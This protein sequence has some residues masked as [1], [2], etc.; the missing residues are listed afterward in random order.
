MQPFFEIVGYFIHWFQNE[1]F[2]LAERQA[3]TRDSVRHLYD[4]AQEGNLAVLT[5]PIEYTLPWLQTANRT[6]NPV[7]E[8]RRDAQDA[9]PAFS[10]FIA[11]ALEGTVLFEGLPLVRRIISRTSR[12]A[13]APVELITD[14]IVIRHNAP[15]SLVIRARVITMPSIPHPLIAIDIHKRLWAQNLRERPFGRGRLSGYAL[16]AGLPI[17]ITFRISP[18]RR[19]YRLGRDYLPIAR[20]FELPTDADGYAIVEGVVSMDAC[21]VLVNHRNGFGRHTVDVGVPEK[22]KIEAFERVCHHLTQRGFEPWKGVS[23]IKT[24]NSARPD[25]GL[26]PAKTLRKLAVDSSPITVT[27]KEQQELERAAQAIE[28]NVQM[29]NDWHAADPMIVIAHHAGCHNDAAFAKRIIYILTNGRSQIE[30]VTV[31]EEAHGPRGNLPHANIDNAAER[32]KL[33]SEAWKKWTE[34]LRESTQA[35]HVVGCLVMAPIWYGNQ[36]DDPVNKP[37]ARKS[38]AMWSGLLVQYLLPMDGEGETA[39]EA[40]CLRIQAAWRDL[41]WAHYGRFKSVLEDVS[42]LFPEGTMPQEIVGIAIV[43]RNKPRFGQQGSAVPVAI[44]LDVATRE[45]SMRFAYRE[46]GGIKITVWEG[47]RQGLVRLAEYSP[48]SMG[49]RHHD[50]IVTF[51]RF[52]KTVIGEACEAGTNPLVL[53]DST[54]SARNWEWLRDTDINSDDISFKYEGTA[55]Q[56]A[57]Q[58]AR[59]IRVREDN[60]PQIVINKFLNLTPL[61]P[62]DERQLVDLSPELQLHVPTSPNAALYRVDDARIPTYLS[63]GSKFFGQRVRGRS[64]YRF[65]QTISRSQQNEVPMF[66]EGGLRLYPLREL[67]PTMNQWPTPNAVEFVMSFLREEDDP[68]K[69][70]EFVEALRF[71]FD[72]YDEW[73]ALPAPLFFMRVVR[74]YLAEF[75]NMENELD[76]D[77]GEEEADEE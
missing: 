71:G 30:L 77:E 20:R 1:L 10:D 4:L 25:S 39:E 14:P 22:D 35:L 29:L 26:V 19:E 5:E 53:I 18:R 55:M 21:Q 52:C 8:S 48:L 43:R 49:R 54:N 11:R 33:R 24:K 51:E 16:P 42:R 47:L 68:D 37:A 12:A 76:D 58:G 50:Q 31:P 59:I 57:W 61:D 13:G 62:S 15:F 56:V 9:Y 27:D 69:L 73:S 23:Q 72:H 34:E 66:S 74:D 32:G 60:A 3:A 63:I 67:T 46:N 45:C 40:F 17:T 41:T 38:I 2:P 6:A 65:S 64:C 36:K 7:R 70:A 28:R 75:S 44:K